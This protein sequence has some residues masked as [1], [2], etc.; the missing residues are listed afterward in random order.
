MTFRQAK[1][2]RVGE[3]LLMK[4]HNFKPTSVL[5]I[6]E[7][8]AARAIFFRSTAG[9]FHHSAVCKAM[10]VDELAALYLKSKHTRVYIS[11]NNEI[12]QWLYSVVVADSDAFWL[13]SFD[14]ELEAKE[15]ISQHGLKMAQ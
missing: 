6:E 12:G 11:H 15:Y 2:V 14:T 3:T 4:G 8:K 10:P 1:K 5:E 13:D 9:L 7:D